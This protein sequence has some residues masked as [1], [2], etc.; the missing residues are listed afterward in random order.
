MVDTEMWKWGE[1]WFAFCDVLF[2]CILSGS[3]IWHRGF[4]K[5]T[6]C[7]FYK[8]ILNKKNEAFWQVQDAL[9]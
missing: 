3:Q 6:V 2:V 7:S 8:L 4:K 5:A 1:K 9:F